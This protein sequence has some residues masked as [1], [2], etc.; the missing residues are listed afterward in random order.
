MSYY[1]PETVPDSLYIL[2]RL[3][4]RGKKSYFSVLEG[5]NLKCK[6][7]SGLKYQATIWTQVCLPLVH[8]LFHNPESGIYPG[9]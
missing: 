6:E 8:K 4:L 3:I 2:S 7:V 9:K 5:K 1:I